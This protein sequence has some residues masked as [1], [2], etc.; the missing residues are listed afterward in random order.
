[1]NKVYQR[2]Y[3]KNGREPSL[4]EYT[5]NAIDSALDTLDDRII[6]QAEDIAK[7]GYTTESYVILDI[8]GQSIPTTMTEVP[9]DSGYRIRDYRYLYFESTM[10]YTDGTSEIFTFIMPTSAI[11]EGYTYSIFRQV[12]SGS[13][14]NNASISARFSMS[15][16]KIEL[17]KRSSGYTVDLLRIYGVY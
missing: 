11:R 9:I 14:G 1:M 10:G 16:T 6:K 15:D 4:N 3:F 12:G 8:F 13:S 17:V 5:L 2:Q 7:A